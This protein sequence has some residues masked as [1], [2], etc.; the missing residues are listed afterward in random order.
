VR[1][2]PNY[3]GGS[4]IAGCRQEMLH[5]SVILDSCMP[6]QSI[7]QREQPFFHDGPNS[8]D[9]DQRDFVR[10]LVE[11]ERRL[12]GFILA[13]VPNWAIAEDIAQETKLR[14]WEQFS[15]FDRSQ[16]FGS[17]ACTIAYYQVLSYRK[18]DKRS[19]EHLFGEDF[20]ESVAQAE[21]KCSEELNA[22]QRFLT[23]CLQKLSEKSRSLLHLVYSGQETIRQI[24]RKLGRS[25]AATY[26]AV[27][28]ARLRL[29]KCIQTELRKELVK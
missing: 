2:V 6:D 29:Y 16:D 24:A 8:P 23:F 5:V 1:L 22:R 12:E 26:R 28:D 15:Q 7:P 11:H 18:S 3:N 21:S 4:E 27:E 25:E 17:W 19:R 9:R 13:L 10:L 14:L 20:L